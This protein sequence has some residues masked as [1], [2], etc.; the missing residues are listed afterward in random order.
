MKRYFA[1][2]AAALVGAV[3]GTSVSSWL[4]MRTLRAVIPAHVA[5]LERDQEYR[6]TLSLAVLGRLEAGE[7]DRA[8]EI[9]AHEVGIFYSHPW[10]A[11]TPQRRKILELVE[12]TKPK[13]SILRE[14]LGKP[15]K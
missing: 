1:W 4:Y 15:P 6:C 9:L 7:T 10:Q 14:E 12:A 13:S 2:F 3:V 5:T 8:K 11:D